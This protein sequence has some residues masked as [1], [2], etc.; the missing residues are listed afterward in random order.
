MAA[1][2][3]KHGLYMGRPTSF[4]PRQALVSSGFLRSSFAMAAHRPA[5]GRIADE[6]TVDTGLK[7]ALRNEFARQAKLSS[8]FVTF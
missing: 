2:P 5:H 6:R 7:Y 8:Q 3:M 1:R 4:G